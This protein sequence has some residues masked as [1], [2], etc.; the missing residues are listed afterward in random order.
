MY[1][2]KT[3]SQK[4]CSETCA[5]NKYKKKHIVSLRWQ[6][7]LRDNF[8]CQYCGAT[9]SD[10][11][12]LHIDHIKPMNEGGLTDK[13]NLITSCNICNFGKGD[14]LIKE[15]INEKQKYCIEKNNISSNK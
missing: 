12:K 14:M 7:L 5:T 6:L 3:P 2:Q 13:N 9:P 11:V 10:G 4:Y 15:I 1:L 8:T